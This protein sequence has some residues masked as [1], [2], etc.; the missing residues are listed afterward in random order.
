MS[1]DNW[2]GKARKKMEA[3]GT[4]G[5]LRSAL[6]VPKGEKIPVAKLQ[7][8]KKNPKL[9]KKANFALNVRKK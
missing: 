2:I 9:A 6:K 1:K 3:K 7:A 5:S 8:A 4:V